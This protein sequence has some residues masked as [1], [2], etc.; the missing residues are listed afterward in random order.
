MRFVEQSYQKFPK[1][2]IFQARGE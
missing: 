1:F 2:R